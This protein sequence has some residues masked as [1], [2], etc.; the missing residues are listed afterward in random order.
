MRDGFGIAVHIDGS[1]VQVRGSRCVFD[2]GPP[3]DSV[4]AD[5]DTP[6]SQRRALTRERRHR[7][8]P[9]AAGGAALQVAGSDVQ[10]PGPP[11]MRRSATHDVVGLAPVTERRARRVAQFGVPMPAACATTH[12]WRLLNGRIC[13]WSDTVRMS[14][15]RKVAPRQAR[16]IVGWPR[17]KCAI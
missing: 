17:A 10:L 7:R 15:G 12:E 8:V 16:W 13:S 5:S 6:R 14:V 11:G 3:F 2:A 1:G 4:I 9:P